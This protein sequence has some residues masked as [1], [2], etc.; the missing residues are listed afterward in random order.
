[1]KKI[2]E[3]DTSQVVVE[4][5]KVLVTQQETVNGE[6][7]EVLRRVPIDVIQ[8]VIE[9]PTAVKAAL[10]ACFEGVAWTDEHGQSRYDELEAALF[11]HPVSIAASF[12]PGSSVIYDTDCLDDL[13]QF[14]T[15]TATYEN[16]AVKNVYGYTLTGSM[17]EGTNTIT[18]IYG[19]K[20]TTFTVTVTAYLP[21]EY[22]RVEW[23]QS[24]GTQVIITDYAP[25]YAELPDLTM[26][27]EALVPSGT[28]SST[29]IFAGFSGWSG[30]W[31]GTMTNGKLGLGNNIGFANV[32]RTQK[33]TIVMTWDS[34][35]GYASC[36]SE[37]IQ[38]ET[39]DKY[40]LKFAMFASYAKAFWAKA[41]IYSAKISDDGVLAVDMIPCYRIADGVIG[42]YDGI[43]RAFYSNEGTGTFTK[44]SDV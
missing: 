27:V 36:G 2:T 35:N 4:S 22:Q 41:R 30:Q 29:E 28:V 39:A 34:S 44:G 15:V 7:V 31:I 9:F 13:K 10:L 37:T 38:R 23:I 20:T 17:A 32:D 18:V 26:T 8:P 25:Q 19:G 3:V 40:E 16:G 43:A 1:M 42:M 33:N 11:S 5:A 6:D 14:L 24:S 21:S 12:N